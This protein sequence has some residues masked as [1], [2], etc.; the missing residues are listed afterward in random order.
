M[1]L[2]GCGQVVPAV[3][4]PSGRTRDAVEYATVC[5]ILI[6]TKSLNSPS[7]KYP[8]RC[9]PSRTNPSFS[10]NRTASSWN[11]TTPTATRCTPMYSNAKSS[12]SRPTS[13][14]YPFPHASRSPIT[15]DMSVVRRS[16]NIRRSPHSPMTF[17]SSSLMITYQARDSPPTASSNHSSASASLMGFVT[18][19]I[20]RS[21]G[22][23]SH[24]RTCARSSRSICRS[25]IPSPMM[26]F[27][28][29]RLRS[30]SPIAPP[31]YRFT[32]AGTSPVPE[33]SSA[34]RF[35]RASCASCSFC[36]RASS[37]PR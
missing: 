5:R 31:A 1:F 3:G 10:Q 25:V 15:I 9:T 21:S 17:S 33:S 22:S 4:Q 24:R 23:S 34:T 12:M 11:P 36:C 19:I 18:P 14:P 7:R 37:A 13:V 8:S 32:D 35:L 2:R 16:G 30:D 29:T 28:P 27:G 26:N 6:I 20:A